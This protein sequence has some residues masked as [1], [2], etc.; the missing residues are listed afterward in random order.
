[1]TNTCTI[2]RHRKVQEINKQLVS[3]ETFQTIANEFKCSAQA[4][5]RHKAHHIPE[6]LKEAEILSADSLTEQ[7]ADIRKTISE[8]LQQ[9][10]ASDNLRDAHNFAGDTLKQ[11]EL[12]GKILGQIKEQT[13]NVNTQINI[14][15]SSEW[16]ELR[17]QILQAIEP[18][19]EAKRALISAL[20]SN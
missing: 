10:I 15:Q 5:Q 19:P 13:I 16:I 2:C 11:I 17:G 18:Y 9:A 20:P 3:G 7:I 4:I 12:E 1:M 8:L 14:L 6:L